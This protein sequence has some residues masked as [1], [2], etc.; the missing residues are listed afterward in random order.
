MSLVITWP[1]VYARYQELAKLPDG[2]S[3]EVQDNLI[4]MAEAGIHSRL[5]G[6]FS[7]PFSSNNYTARDLCVDM[8]YV[9]N[10]LTR[11]PEKAKALAE[12]LDK[13]IDDLLSGKTSM[14]TDAGVA[15]ATMVGDTIWSSSQEYSPVFGM[16]AIECA[17]VSSQQL[18]DE[19]ATRGEYY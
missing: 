19:A 17:V 18:S 1:D 9:Q 8:L 4:L 2:T 11:Q 10:M 14:V 6:N 15:T 5:A 16:G 3:P 12:N 13:R 7:T